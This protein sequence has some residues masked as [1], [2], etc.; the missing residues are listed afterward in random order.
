MTAPRWHVSLLL[1]CASAAIA[2]R[3]PTPDPAWGLT[4]A[5]AQ[6][7][8]DL[9]DLDVPVAAIVEAH[10]GR[11]QFRGENTL[12]G[13]TGTDLVVDMSHYN[14][15]D[16]PY[17]VLDFGREIAGR[18]VLRAK[19]A[20]S[21]RVGTGESLD[22]A[23]IKPFNKNQ[24]L[25]AGAGGEAYTEYT[26][27]RYIKI[28]FNRGK[29]KIVHFDKVLADYHHYPVTYQG[30]FDC[31]DPEL[32]KI[33][34]VGAYTAHLCM[35]NDVWD[36]PKRDR[37]Q[38]AGDFHV[39]GRVINTVFADTF[40]MEKTLVDLRQA[41]Q[42]GR[43]ESELPAKHVSGIPGYSSAWIA[44]L[45]D[46]HRYVGDQD[47]LMS[48]RQPLITLI[49]FMR[50]DLDENDLFKGKLF[51]W[52]FVD[53]SPAITQPDSKI[54]THF[55]MIRAMKEA[56]YL[57]GEMG[58]GENQAK[59]LALAETMARAAREHF[60]KAGIFSDTRQVNAMAV[61]S[62]APDGEERRRIYEN[63][64]RPGSPSWNQIATPYYNFYVIE[65]LRDLGAVDDALD[66]LHDFWGGMLDEG[67]TTFWEAYDPS[68]PKQHFHEYLKA[69]DT[70]GFW[71]SL[72]HGWSA[73]PT[74][75]LTETVLG[76]RPTARGFSRV[77]IMPELGRLKWAKGDVPTPRGP[78]HVDVKHDWLKIDLPA[79]TQAT[80]RLPWNGE[81]RELPGPGHYELF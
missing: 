73:G 26:A 10:P 21:T 63:V 52:E 24:R 18:V 39:E 66:V 50:Q 12:L 60:A 14:L 47:F 32:T 37:L 31:S 76:V 70:E 19:Q 67:A 81:V 57:F 71:I 16:P 15:F 6:S 45:A 1:F 40:L 33:W 20:L 48:Q 56:A 25:K 44:T 23:T 28:T 4:E 8:S 79:E 17:L 58:D 22:E 62:G 30:S 29:D 74:T 51:Q 2:D 13:T 77:E 41:A 5:P 36:A 54:A 59:S 53:W 61:F 55:F 35:Q 3:P 34:Y 43:P 46:F 78:I 9:R 42:G 64:L 38:W 11:S 68:W 80:V 72:S 75:W 69:D 65:A 7:A 49:E 27:F